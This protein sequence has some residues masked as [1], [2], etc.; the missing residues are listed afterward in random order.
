MG[1]ELCHSS[2]TV[3]IEPMQIKRWWVHR[4]ELDSP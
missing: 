4:G 2:R 3:N 1:E